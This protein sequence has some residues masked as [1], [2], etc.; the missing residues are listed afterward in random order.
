MA[1]VAIQIL[2]EEVEKEVYNRKKDIEMINRKRKRAA[3]TKS[4]KT[5]SGWGN[6]TK[7][8]VA[9]KKGMPMLFRS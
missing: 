5:D 6:S 2:K 3:R 1:Y 7:R 9:N 8:R 4:R